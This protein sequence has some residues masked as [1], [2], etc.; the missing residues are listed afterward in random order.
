MPR[1]SEV[2]R[3]I[4]PAPAAGH[5]RFWANEEHHYG[6]LMGEV[7]TRPYGTF[8]PGQLI[9]APPREEKTYEEVMKI[10]AAVVSQ[11]RLAIGLYQQGYFKGKFGFAEFQRY[12]NSTKEEFP[13]LPSQYFM[14]ER[15]HDIVS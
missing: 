14:T 9:A 12:F 7:V 10:S 13:K 3:D 4:R 6:L 15:E 8:R 1:L 5:N 2:I 11:K